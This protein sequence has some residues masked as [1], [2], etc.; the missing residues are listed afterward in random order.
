GEGWGPQFAEAGIAPLQVDMLSI[1]GGKQWM[2]DE[3]GMSN[4]G[5]VADIVEGIR[6]EGG[7]DAIT[8]LFNSAEA[9]LQLWEQTEA[10]SANARQ[11]P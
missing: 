11:Q 6:L 10:A 1:P 8:A 5:L 3:E 2:M 9:Y 4:Y 7:E